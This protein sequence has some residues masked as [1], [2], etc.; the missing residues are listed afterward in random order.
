MVEYI[1]VSEEEINQFSLGFSLPVDGFIR[2]PHSW[3]SVSTMLGLQSKSSIQ[4]SSCD[5]SSDANQ[6]LTNFI[7]RAIY[8]EL[9]PQLQP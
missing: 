2:F 9:Q 1:M 5:Y 4:I 7:R 8:I 3:C 6:S